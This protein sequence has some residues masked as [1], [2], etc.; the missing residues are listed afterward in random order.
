MH[1]V[2]LMSWLLLLL[3]VFLPAPLDEWLVALLCCWRVWRVQAGVS[4]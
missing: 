2:L 1:G 4:C 3:V